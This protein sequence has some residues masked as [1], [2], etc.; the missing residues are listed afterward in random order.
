MGI[1]DTTVKLMKMEE[2]GGGWRRME[3]DVGRWRRMEEDGGR[4]RRMEEDG[5]GWKRMEEDG[6]AAEVVLMR[7]L[8]EMFS[9]F[10]HC[11]KIFRN[12]EMLW[13]F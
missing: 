11:F 1:C 2:D 8:T 13:I 3:E 9:F 4:W 5:G 12:F 6:E 10:L 7:C